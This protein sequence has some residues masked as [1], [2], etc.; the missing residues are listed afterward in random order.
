MPL[1]FRDKISFMNEKFLQAYNSQNTE[2]RISQLWEQSGFYN[3]DEMIG[4]QLTKPD[5]KTFSIVLPPPNVT[6]TLHTGHASMLAIEDI[7][8]R[9]NRM[10]GK[11]TLWI[12]GTDHAAIATQS[13]VEKILAKDKIRKHDLGR[14]EF[15]KRVEAFAQESHDTIVSQCKKMGASLDWSREAFTLDEQRQTPY[16]PHLSVCIMT[17]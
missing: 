1:P 4:A 3:P 11:R 17:V 15:L 9:Y 6:G 12:P 14:E 7:M 2:D 5:A 16:T 10:L 8:V 13:K